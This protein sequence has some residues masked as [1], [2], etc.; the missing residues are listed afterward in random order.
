MVT[1]M[2]A[3]AELECPTSFKYWAK[4]DEPGARRF[5]SIVKRLTGTDA[6]PTD[7][8]ARA[9]TADL[10]AGDPVA[11]RYIDE[12]FDGP[13]GSK[14]GRE[15]LDE[16]LVHGIDAVEDAPEAMKAL[17][18]E[19]EDVPDWVKP[20][21]VEQGAAIWRRWGT[22]LF[23]IAGTTTLGMYTEAAVATPLSLAG[24]YAGDNALRRFLETG[25]FWIDVSE[26]GALLEPG[27]K[28]RATAMRVR[29]MHVSVRRRVEGHPEWDT[30]KWGLPIS[31]SYMLLTLIG[32]SVAPALALWTLGYQ[33]SKK[34]IYALIHFQRYMGYLLG[35]RA[36]WYP[37]TIPDVLRTLAMVLVS[38]AFD[39]GEHG[40]ELI[41]SFPA[42]FAP[43]DGHRGLRRLR[44]MYNYRIYSAYTTLFMPPSI[45]KQYNLPRAFPWILIPIVRF[46]FITALELVRRTVPGMNKIVEKIN[47][48]HR[49]NWY[50]AQM[51]G[52][53]AKF[54]AT[55]A[56]RR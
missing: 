48:R 41:E 18:A 19:F 49:E 39:A 21:L 55:G 24:G 15:M 42:G 45:R 7:T 22:M 10:F 20:E 28:G 3:A 37:E 51:D 16:A 12:V 27:S 14:R 44:E 56:L 53:E 9:F 40:A 36:R 17:F 43:R 46:P 29:V 32:G 54:D 8:Q 6:F 34:E 33:T 4:R 35:V 25:R 1:E 13:I 52:R 11:E 30:E 2:A 38:R 31:Q 5:R 50:R 23:A 47:M 26:Q